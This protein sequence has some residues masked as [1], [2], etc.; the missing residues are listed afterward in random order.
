MAAL[1]AL[2][3]YYRSNAAMLHNVYR[4]AAE[5]PALQGPIQGFQAYLDV[6]HAGLLAMRSGGQRKLRRLAATLA[7][8]LAFSTWSSL[9]GLELSDMEIVRLVL[10]WI[11][12]SVD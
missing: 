12:A 7:H 10:T 2:Y 1:T 5:V 11:A 4:D 8:V 6:V 9:S 3:A